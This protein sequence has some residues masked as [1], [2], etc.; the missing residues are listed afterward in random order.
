VLLEHYYAREARG[1]LGSSGLVRVGA[2]G[3]SMPAGGALRSQR[4]VRR[5]PAA[6][7]AGLPW[8]ALT[9]TNTKPCIHAGYSGPGVIPHAKDTGSSA[10]SVHQ[11]RNPGIGTAPRPRYSLQIVTTL[12]GSVFVF[13]GL[14]PVCPFPAR[15]DRPGPW[16]PPRTSERTSHDRA[17]C[18][19][20]AAP[21]ESLAAAC[22]ATATPAAVTAASVL[23]VA[24]L[25]AALPAPWR[26]GAAVL[27]PAGWLDSKSWEG[28]I[29]SAGSHPLARE[30]GDYCLP[31]LP[32]ERLTGCG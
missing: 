16:P 5:R 28:P 1:N 15:P 18:F 8:Q 6:A 4:R 22:A 23:G 26:E 27:A 10:I 21:L 31:R 9:S 12:D 13:V 17:Q 7:I 32:R 24:A 19:P 11:R 3:S 25:P 2:H 20:A 14:G 30:P 29:A